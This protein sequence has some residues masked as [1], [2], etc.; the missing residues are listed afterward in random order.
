MYLDLR[1]ASFFDEKALVP[2]MASQ[3]RNSSIMRGICFFV[4]CSSSAGRQAA[5]P[6]LP[7]RIINMNTGINSHLV[8]LLDPRNLN[9]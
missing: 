1:N 4:G 5:A 2:S 7:D 6:I 9:K 3:T 8:L